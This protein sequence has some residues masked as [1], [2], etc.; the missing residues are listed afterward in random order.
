MGQPA[1]SIGDA[2]DGTPSL[3]SVAFDLATVG[4]VGHE[5]FAIGTSTSYSEARAFEP[6]GTWEVIESTTEPFTTRLVVYRP[7]D[8]QRGNGTVVVAWLNVTGGLDVPALWMPAHR[9][10]LREGVTWV[11][12]SVQ[13]VGIEGGGMMPGF[14]LRQTTPE[15]YGALDH[16]GDEYSYDIFTQVARAL[17]VT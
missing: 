7:T 17:R 3:F 2:L 16:P 5:H 11:G 9:Q 14:G 8:A 12:V 4:Y 13:R 15:R 1:A 6:D 10:F